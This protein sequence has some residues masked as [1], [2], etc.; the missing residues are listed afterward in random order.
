MDFGWLSGCMGEGATAVRLWPD[1]RFLTSL[2]PMLT[3]PV[4]VHSVTHPSER[5]VVY[6]VPALGMIGE[7]VGHDHAGMCDGI[8][9][10]SWP[11]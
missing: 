2:P 6:S 11:R 1:K 10:D 9:R 5:G 3:R 8:R 4:I 7:N